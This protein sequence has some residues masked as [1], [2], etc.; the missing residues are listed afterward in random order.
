MLCGL[1]KSY[2]IFNGFQPM[3]ACCVNR[4]TTMKELTNKL[5]AD[6]FEA[7]TPEQIRKIVLPLMDEHTLQDMN[8][9]ALFGSDYFTKMILSNIIIPAKRQTK[10]RTRK[11]IVKLWEAVKDVRQMKVIV[12]RGRSSDK[13]AFWVVSVFEVNDDG[14]YHTKAETFE[15]AFLA[16][17]Y[18]EWTMV[19][20]DEANYDIG[21]VKLSSGECVCFI[22]TA[23]A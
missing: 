2:Y 16:D 7:L 3:R 1:L 18:A 17:E 12:S 9:G 11:Q 19:N 10:A 14:T 6:E 22:G 23:K 4:H 15:D 21:I 8:F 20:E 13:G 5:T